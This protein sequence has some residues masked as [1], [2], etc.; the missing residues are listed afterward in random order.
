MPPHAAGDVAGRTNVVVSALDANRRIA[1]SD[2]IVIFD[3]VHVVPAMKADR[4]L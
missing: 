4:M 1:E 3:L 2:E